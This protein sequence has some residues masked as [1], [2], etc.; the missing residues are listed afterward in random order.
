MMVSVN[1]YSHPIAR[2]YAQDIEPLSHGYRL[3]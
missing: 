2:L 3:T 1:A